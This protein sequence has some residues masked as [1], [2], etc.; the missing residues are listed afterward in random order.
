MFYSTIGAVQTRATATAWEQ[1]DAIGV[2][3]LT[4]GQALPGGIYNEK[5][6]IKYTTASTDGIFKAASIGIQFLNS[7]DKLDFISYYPYK[8]T[9]NNYTYPINVSAQS[10][11]ET[12]DLMYSNNVK[13]S[14][15]G[16]SLVNLNFKHAL[17]QLVFSITAG[18][19]ITSLQSITASLSDVVVDGAFDLASGNVTMGTTKQSLAPKVYNTNNTT[20]TVSVILLPGQ[21]T[22]DVVVSFT[23]NG[24]IYKFP[25]SEVILASS[26]KY[27]YQLVLSKTGLTAV[28]ANATITDWVEG[29]PGGSPITITPDDSP[30]FAVNKNAVT[31]EASGTLSDQVSVT[32][33]AVQAW[34]VSDNADWLTVTPVSGTG[35]QTITLTAAE[36]TTNVQ[37]TATVTVTPTGT[38]SF[39]PTTINV[40]QKAAGSVPTPTTGTLLFPGSDF[41]DWNAFLGTLNSYG[42]K[43]DYTSQSND[44]RNASK[45]LYLNGTPAGNDYV[46]TTLVPTGLSLAGKTKIVFYIKGTA[47]KSLSMNV[48]VGAGSTMGTDYKCYNLGD[49]TTEKTITPTAS[50]DYA[51]TIN[52]NGEWIKV[53]LDISSLTVNSTVGQNLFAIKVGRSAAYDLLIDDITVE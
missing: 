36:N 16:T 37:R 12:I 7:E 46:F 3:A 19:G 18:D 8:E 44:G 9:I 1:G 6:N 23:L 47:A 26:S 14:E 45:A 25:L 49:C 33:D 53:T 21:N 13:N 29:N 28:D 32:T 39:A 5:A 27:T 51:G 17:S 4:A 31:L 42:L 43:T 52:T 48:Y 40:T 2:Y 24:S 35:A 15:S 38:T 20:A 34:T 50:N 30:V 41:E 11:P 10:S 22:K